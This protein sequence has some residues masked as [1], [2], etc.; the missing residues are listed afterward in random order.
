MPCYFYILYSSTI[1]TYYVGHTCESLE[2]RL[3]KHNS[4]TK[5]Y[6]G[7]AQDWRVVYFETFPSKKEAYSRERIVKQWKSRKM[8]ESLI[9]G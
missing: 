7:K 3:R 9:A 8:L 5:G 6:T 2:E 1:D 4:G